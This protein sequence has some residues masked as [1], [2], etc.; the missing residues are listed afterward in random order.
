MKNIGGR[1]AGSI[2]AGQFL[3]RFVGTNTP[4]AHI[5][6][7]GTAMKPSGRH[8]P[9]ETT[10]GTGFGARLLNRWIADNFEG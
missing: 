2:T 1:G 8:D 4:W 6:I 9:R 7:A 5:D 3:Q 10:F